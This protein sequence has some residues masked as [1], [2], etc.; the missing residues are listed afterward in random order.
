MT[1]I[2][3][4]MVTI[5]IIMIMMMTMVMMTSK[6]DGIPYNLAGIV[7]VVCCRKPFH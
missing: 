2:M 5:T 4:I 7:K 1:M 3:T 6:D